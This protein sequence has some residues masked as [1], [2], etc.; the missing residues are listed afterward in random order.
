MGE[1]PWSP[2]RTARAREAMYAAGLVLPAYLSARLPFFPSRPEGE[3]GE[4][5]AT[6]IK[7]N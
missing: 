2:E 5:G 4:E 3:G 7:A 6:L 1:T